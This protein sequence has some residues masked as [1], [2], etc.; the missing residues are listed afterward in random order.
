MNRVPFVIK[1][2]FPKKVVDEIY[3]P[4]GKLKAV[5]NIQ[6]MV[7]FFLIVSARGQ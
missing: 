7:A 6:D 5:R 3:R 1:V 4:L 2:D